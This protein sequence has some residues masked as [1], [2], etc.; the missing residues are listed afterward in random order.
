MTRKL[1]GQITIITGGARGI[2][3][4]IAKRLAADGAQVIIWDIRPEYFDS[5]AA[6]FEPIDTMAVDVADP[7]SVATAA[8]TV[9]TTY[10]APSI[11]VN[12]AGIN[13][14]VVPVA[15]YDFETWRRVI[16]VNLDSVFLVSRAFVPAM[17]EKSYGRIVTV[18]SIAGKEGVPGIAAYASAKAGAI[19]FTKSLAK[20]LVTSGVTVN[21][22]A[23]VMVETELLEQMTAEHIAASKAKIPMQR[24]LGIEELAAVVAFA[25]SPECSCTTGFVFDASGGRATY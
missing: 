13:G 11:V 2:G 24:L 19:G 18:A 12:N 10:G 5:V 6:G 3:R 8:Q 7:E 25:A 15:D 21:A 23:P 22:V 17:V 1:E 9:L 4:G 20:E 16:Q 14:P